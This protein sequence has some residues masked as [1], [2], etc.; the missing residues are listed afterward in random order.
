MGYTHSELPGDLRRPVCY[1]AAVAD[2]GY[3]F[4]MDFR[5]VGRRQID[6]RGT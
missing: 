4:E 6:I 1:P 5:A 3:G 2:I